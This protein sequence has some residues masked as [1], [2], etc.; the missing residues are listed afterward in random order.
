MYKTSQGWYYTA[1][2]KS[3]ITVIQWKGQTI[4]MHIV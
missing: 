2:A 3:D 4:E 1:E